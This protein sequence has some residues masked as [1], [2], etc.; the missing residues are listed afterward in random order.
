MS[1]EQYKFLKS[2]RKYRK[3][4]KVAF[5]PN[6]SDTRARLER[7]IIEKVPKQPKREKKVIEPEEVKD[8]GQDE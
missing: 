5:N 4:D 6:H 2:T 8:E 1:T 3:G 7:G